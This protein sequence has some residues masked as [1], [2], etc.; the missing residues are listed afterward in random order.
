M[1]ANALYTQREMEIQNM[2]MGAMPFDNNQRMYND[3][4]VNNG[5]P[6]MNN[7]YADHDQRMHDSSR[8]ENRAMPN[9]GKE[10]G[11]AHDRAGFID[12]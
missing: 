7:G 3:G 5:G 1:L 11:T 4:F 8:Y 9:S 12:A 10:K 2:E 6:R